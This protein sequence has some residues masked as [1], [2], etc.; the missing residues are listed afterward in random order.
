RLFPFAS[1]GGRT[2]RRCSISTWRASTRTHSCG[3]APVCQAISSRS[4]DARS[5]KCD[6]I[7]ARC[8][9]LVTCSRLPGAGLGRVADRV[10]G[11]D[12]HLLGPAEGPLDGGLG[13]PLVGRTPGAVGVDPP[14]D[15]DRP[16]LVNGESAVGSPLVLVPDERLD[17]VTVPHV[18]PRGPVL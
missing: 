11:D 9:G 8:S 15:V 3:R 7:A 4:R 14:L 6:R 5:G 18:G 16:D 12:P 2:I 1:A 17:V 13:P 10:L